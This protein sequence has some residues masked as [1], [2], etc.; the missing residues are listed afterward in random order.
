MRLSSWGLKKNVKCY[1]DCKMRRDENETENLS[2]AAARGPLC[3]LSQLGMM[4]P[5]PVQSARPRLGDYHPE[6]KAKAVAELGGPVRQAV[7][8]KL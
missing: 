3:W 7:S 8:L 6:V 4:P 2:W 5:V 1:N